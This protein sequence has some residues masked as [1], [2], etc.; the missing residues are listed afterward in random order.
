MNENGISGFE[1]EEL[2]LGRPAKAAEQP[3]APENAAETAAVISAEAGIET[4]A[5][6]QLPSAAEQEP[7][8]E[9]ATEA[10]AEGEAP[11]QED[12]TVKET[13]APRKKQNSLAKPEKKKAAAKQ[14]TA[15]NT[16]DE[17]AHQED[18]IRW[19]MPGILKFLVWLAFTLAASLALAYFAWLCAGDVFALSKPDRTVNITITQEDT[20]DDVIEVL[21]DEGLVDYE[22]LFRIYCSLAKA[23][24]KISVGTFTLNNAYDYNALIKG[25]QAYSGTRE[26]TEVTI[27]EGYTCK[28]IFAALEEAG[29]CTVEELETAAASYMFDYSFLQHL[30]YGAANRLEGYLF[31]D[32][33]EFYINDNP[34]RVLS[35]F[36]DNFGWKFEQELRDDIAVLNETLAQQMRENGIS[37][38]KI[39]ESEL[40]M[41][42]VVIVA[43]LV[44]RETSAASESSKIASV[45]YNRLC[46]DR[47]PL[48]EI[49][50]SVR[51]GLDKWEGALNNADLSKDTPYNTRKNPGLPAGPISNPGLDSIRAALYPRNT[52][53]YFYVLSPE[54]SHH[55]SET[56]YEHQDY[57]EEMQ[58]SGN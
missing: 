35:K 40:D 25:L 20:L 14:K 7:A 23:E 32:T 13:S 11:A 36:L 39:Q 6:E 34:E 16:M 49:D 45:I 41:H 10:V 9:A 54:G 5:S 33:Y 47:Y 43:S 24:E 53:Y 46:S 4:D 22:W 44:E 48:L 31:P 29:V 17:P 15:N 37:E 50:A 27:P 56:Y 21:V 2:P 38:E 51:Y 18:V 1:L 12:T 52:D 8:E 30:P 19:R 58:K 42:D 28:Q 26:T 55:F 3:A 57:I